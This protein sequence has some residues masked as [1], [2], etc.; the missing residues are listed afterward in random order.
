LGVV[1]VAV[2]GLPGGLTG[3]I[4]SHLH[5]NRYLTVPGSIALAL[6][7]GMTAG[8][9]LGSRCWLRYTIS[10]TIEAYRGNVPMAFERFTDWAYGAGIL[11]ISGVS[12]QFRHD[13]LRSSLAPAAKLQNIAP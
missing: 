5:L 8:V 4:L 3:G 6:V 11:R 1:Y 13:K 7:I 9:T 10:I 2:G 12:Y